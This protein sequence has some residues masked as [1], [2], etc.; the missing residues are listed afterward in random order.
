MRF[1]HLLFKTVNRTMNDWSPL[2]ADV[3]L[4]GTLLVRVINKRDGQPRVGKK[5]SVFACGYV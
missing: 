5:V 2:D 1:G 4:K 3:L